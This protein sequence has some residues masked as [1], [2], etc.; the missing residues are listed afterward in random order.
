MQLISEFCLCLM[1]F[2]VIV[3]VLVIFSYPEYYG[4]V[5]LIWE[6]LVFM[7]WKKIWK[8]LGNLL[9]ETW[10]EF[11]WNLW[12]LVLFIMF[13]CTLYF[14]SF[15]LNSRDFIKFTFNFTFTRLLL[16]SCRVLPLEWPDF[17][18]FYDISSHW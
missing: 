6:L 1:S 3:L 7:L 4:F 15:K 9:A 2:Y 8:H 16:K 17:L 13:L 11:I 18:S 12:C 10:I 14:C 5:K